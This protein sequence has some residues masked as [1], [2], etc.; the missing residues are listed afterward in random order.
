MLRALGLLLL[1][2]MIHPLDVGWCRDY[3]PEMV[4]NT[5]HRRPSD[6]AARSTSL[7]K[8]VQDVQHS[9]C[10]F[11]MMVHV[12]LG[13]PAAVVCSGDIDATISVACQHRATK[14]RSSLSAQGV[15]SSRF[16]GYRLELVPALGV[17]D[18]SRLLNSRL[19]LPSD[20][21]GHSS[22]DLDIA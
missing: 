15:A 6:M 18:N 1:R 9:G 16:G 5:L 17:A 13:T 10:P 3:L 20:P 12:M 4:A 11:A 22:Y 14:N 19:R 2:D 21:A 7:A 8:T